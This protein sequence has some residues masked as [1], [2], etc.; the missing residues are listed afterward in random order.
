MQTILYTRNFEEARKEITA[1]GGRV[2]QKFGN[3]V[4]VAHVPSLKLKH[5]STNPLSDIPGDV[6]LMINSWNRI[7]NRTTVDPLDGLPIDQ[8]GFKQY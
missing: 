3:N 2:T 6:Q 4:F 7:V 8:P 5:S 1:R